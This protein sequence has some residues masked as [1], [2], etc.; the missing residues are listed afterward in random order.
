M[1]KNIKCYENLFP[2]LKF[3]SV[4]LFVTFECLQYSNHFN[5]GFEMMIYYVEQTIQT[6]VVDP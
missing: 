1:S 5:V 2:Y 3:C 4:F 6:K